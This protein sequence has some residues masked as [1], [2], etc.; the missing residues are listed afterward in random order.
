[1]KKY[2]IFL[3]ID[4]II[5]GGNVMKWEFFDTFN[6]VIKDYM[7]EYGEGETR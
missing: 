3:N 7:P 4:L 5:T 6:D 2:N 1:M